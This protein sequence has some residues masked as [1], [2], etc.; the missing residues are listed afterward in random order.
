MATTGPP[1]PF[2]ACQTKYGPWPKTVPKGST[3]WNDG[4]HANMSSFLI[5]FTNTGVKGIKTQWVSFLTANKKTPSFATFAHG[6]ITGRQKAT[7]RTPNLTS[8]SLH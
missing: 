1:V 4:Q 3:A 2:K 7:V 6:T 8:P 5:S